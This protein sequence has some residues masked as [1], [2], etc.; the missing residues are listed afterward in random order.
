MS[1]TLLLALAACAVSCAAAAEV[2]DSQPD[3]FTIK[4]TATIAASPAK[5]W[6]T[7]IR[8]SAWWSSDHTYSHDARNLSLDPKAG[9]A[10]IET[11]P[12]GGGVRHMEV[13]Y[14]DPP[15]VLR[16]EGALGPL[17]AMGGSGHMTVTLKPRGEATD[18]TLTYDFGGHTPGGLKPMAPAVDGVLAEQLTRLKAAAEKGSA[19]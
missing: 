14:I 5:V 15:S 18:V 9:G 7:L 10:W 1:R 19:P 16:L 2:V 8:P 4:E 11:L 12:G 3:G 13:V 17:Q 6:A